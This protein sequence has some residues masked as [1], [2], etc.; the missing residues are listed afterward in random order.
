MS[1]ATGMTFTSLSQSLDDYVEQGTRNNAAYQR[2]KPQIINQAER[3]LA[4]RLKIQGYRDVMTGTLSPQNPTL[5]KPTGWRNTVTFSIGTGPGF[6]QKR[7]L[8]ARSFEYIAQVFPDPTS[9]DT[10]TLYTD[11][12]F[13]NWII[14]A[15]PDQAYPFEIIVYRLPDLLSSDNQQNYLTNLVPNLL[16]FQCLTNLEPFLKNDPR[17]VTW[18]S[19]L[20]DEL[21]AVNAQ[22]I[23][24]V[25][26]RTLSRT[27]Q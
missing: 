3:S 25:V 24:K 15:V 12:D 26:D 14:G 10:P 20:K 17:M 27:S 2:Q 22:E 9:F 7:L 13:N 23:A 19:M 5:P 1:G 16:L 4:D 8:R 18:K 21:A 6:V 11:Y